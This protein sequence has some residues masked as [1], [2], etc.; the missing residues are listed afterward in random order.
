MLDL[1]HEGE[2]VSAG[3]RFCVSNTCLCALGASCI[4]FSS[5]LG[6]VIIIHGVLDDGVSSIFV[7]L[8][9]E[10]LL[11]DFLGAVGVLLEE[12][13]GQDRP[14]ESVAVTVGVAFLLGEVTLVAVGTNLVELGAADGV[15]EFSC[16]VARL[17][18]MDSGG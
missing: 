13:A 4:V 6:A 15:N 7:P 14:T 8:A 18:G 16:R 5:I 9:V 3:I 10:G 11:E 1:V 12:P 17:D 2:F